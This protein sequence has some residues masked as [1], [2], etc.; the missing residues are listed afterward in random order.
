MTA[1]TGKRTCRTRRTSCKAAC[2]KLQC[3]LWVACCQQTDQAAE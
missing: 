3:A 1:A 2:G